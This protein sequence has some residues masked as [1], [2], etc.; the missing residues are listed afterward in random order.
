MNNPTD[1]AI[2]KDV[3]QAHEH[4]QLTSQEI[5]KAIARH[6]R[7]HGKAAPQK[8]QKKSGK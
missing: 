4:S 2:K 6:N 5:A 3:L 1:E 7:E 8:A